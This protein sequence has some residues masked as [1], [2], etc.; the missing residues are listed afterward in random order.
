MVS[1]G[2]SVVT[3]LAVS[4]VIV[5]GVRADSF[6][7][8][9]GSQSLWLACTRSD[10]RHGGEIVFAL[11]DERGKFVIPSEIRPQ[12]GQIRLTAVRGR[13]LHVM[14]DDGVHMSYSESTGNLP[15]TWLADR[16][17]PAAL[18][19]S[20][21]GDRLYAVVET[22]L[23]EK[24]RAAATFP[25]TTPSSRGTATGLAT[26]SA[27]ARSKYSMVLYDRERWAIAAPLPDELVTD[28]PR[29]LMAA[30]GN[31][32]LLAAAGAGGSIRHAEYKNGRWIRLGSFDPEPSLQCYRLLGGGSDD[33][34]LL[35]LVLLEPVGEGNRVKVRLARYV[36]E[37]WVMAGPVA[38]Q[39][40]DLV[41]APKDFTVAVW[42]KR[43]AMFH[44]QSDG[45]VLWAQVDPD[46][47]V[48][49]DFTSVA[50]F[51]PAPEPAL[52][53]ELKAWLTPLVLIAILA[54]MYLRRGEGLVDAVALPPN[55]RLAPLWRRGV[56]TTIDLLPA[57]VLTVPL[58]W[59][60]IKVEKVAWERLIADPTTI[61]ASLYGVSW[62]A[63][64]IYALYCG[65]M[66]AA[67]G[68]TAGKMIGQ[69]RVI[70]HLGDRPTLRQIGI[71]NAV[72]LVELDPLLSIWW[73]VILVLLTR[74]RQRLGDILA[75]T[76]VIQTDTGAAAPGTGGAEES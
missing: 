18:A 59:S 57:I 61:S 8:C 30:G 28:Q 46:G 1:P 19:V 44:R 32:H 4:A 27:S 65:A 23:A 62:V 51:E 31:L 25:A 45:S 43:I 60:V 54:V 73:V 58:W 26:T 50:V 63:R 53:P 47:R 68:Q 71:R 40:A 67:L 39:G 64:A 72:R 14:Y 21:D 20:P 11:L 12:V 48:V 69:C 6:V 35:V 76:V 55:T 36:N 49:E 2:A 42:K 37:R 70:S 41:V 3:V 17:V 24:L 7:A 10:P 56:G 66:E 13:R 9:G 52:S 15:E 33:P 29:F 5:S 16:Y 74:N 75:G 22:W 38:S 34:E